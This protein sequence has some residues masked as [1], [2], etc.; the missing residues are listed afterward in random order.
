MIDKKI[1]TD[2]VNKAIENSKLFLVDLTITKDNAIT[3]E[4]DSPTSVGIDEC[5]TLSKEIESNLDRE[6][7]DFEL[8][9]GS[10][11]LTSPFKVKAQYDKNIG[12]E[13][14]VLTT[15]GQKFKGVLNAATDDDFTILTTKKVKPEGAKRPIMVEEEIKLTYKETKYTKY[16]IQFK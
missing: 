8:E 4:V 12:N 13:V 10:A 2:I 9:V 16:L 1:L 6:K 3:I 11:G 7:E 14:E 15:D 5:I